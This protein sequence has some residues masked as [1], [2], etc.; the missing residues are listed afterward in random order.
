MFEFAWYCNHV[1]IAEKVE[2]RCIEFSSDLTN[3]RSIIQQNHTISSCK[4]Y[5]LCSKWVYDKPDSLVAE[6]QLACQEWKR[7]LIGSAHTFGYMFGI[8][9]VG[10][11]S[12]RFGRKTLVIITGITGGALGCLKSFA[13][14]YW[15]YVGLEFL[16]AAIGDPLSPI[17]TLGLL[18]IFF[19]YFLDESPRWLLANGK[20]MEALKII[21]NAAK[22]N[23]MEIAQNLNTIWFEQDKG[24]SFATITNYMAGL[25]LSCITLCIIYLSTSELFPTQS[26]N[27]MHALCS[28][29]GRVSAVLAPQT[30]LLMP[31]WAGLPTLTF[32]V[33]A[34]TGGLVTLL[35]P[36]T[37]DQCLPDTVCEAEEM[38]IIARERRL[39]HC[40]N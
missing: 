26:R 3:I 4:N 34:L 39:G 33:V 2:Y 12:D 32:G 38:E 8:L 29:V 36:D 7:T 17:Y 25:L 23:N 16:E 13:T 35:V 11:L 18:A 20:K 40:S 9:I 10:L 28:G 31:Y 22:L 14:S 37:A 27:S 6:F 30:P 21:R 19:I 24:P 15:L 1:L 5:K